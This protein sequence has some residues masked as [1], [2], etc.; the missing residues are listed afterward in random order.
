MIR[1][2]LK[3]RGPWHLQ[4][5]G[6]EHEQVDPFPRSDTLSAALLQSYVRLFGVES[7]PVET[8]W[9]YRVSSVFP[10]IRLGGSYLQLYPKP[11]HFVVDIPDIPGFSHKDFKKAKW[12]TGSL[13]GKI[14]AG[15]EITFGSLQPIAGNQVLALKQENIDTDE[16]L[17]S[18]ETRTRVVLDRIDLSA[19]PF[20]FTSR[21]AGP[22]LYWFF[23]ADVKS[24]FRESFEASLR[25]LGDEGIGADRTI[26]LGQFEVVSIDETSNVSTHDPN[27]WLNLG[28]YNP[29]DEERIRL[30]WDESF[31]DIVNRQ[32]WTQNPALRRRN[33][34]MVDEGAVLK[35]VTQPI[36]RVVTVLD[37]NDPDATSSQRTRLTE[38]SH[39]VYRDGQG[40][41][42][43]VNLH[44]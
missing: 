33:V 35:C 36:G 32:G 23:L 16:S 39:K 1:V 10:A 28:L 25:L 14:C 34:R 40:F 15:G 18:S 5:G 27:A 24:D 26:G 7:V 11:K 41:F 22:N 9:P 29:P 44:Q 38:L 2:I 6:L 37:P 3:P 4:T 30:A 17:G 12:V 19:V 20:Q 21:H 43:P 8:A 31:Y 13:M 42:L